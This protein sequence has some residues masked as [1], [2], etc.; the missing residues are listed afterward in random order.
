MMDFFRESW[1]NPHQLRL[2]SKVILLALFVHVYY[3]Q[4]FQ[5][6]QNHRPLDL[7]NHSW[8]SDSEDCACFDPSAFFESYLLVSSRQGLQIE[9]RCR[10][11]TS[12]LP[13]LLNPHGSEWRSETLYCS[14]YFDTNSLPSMLRASFHI[15]VSILNCSASSRYHSPW[16]P[17]N[18]LLKGIILSID[19]CK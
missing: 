18:T 6:T 9:F 5:R 12:L 16:E 8:F 17:S 3:L 1:Q 14:C 2:A 7:E 19:V 15:S 13:T 4:I 10:R 11:Q